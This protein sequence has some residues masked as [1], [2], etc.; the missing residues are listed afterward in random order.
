MNIINPYRFDSGI[1]GP[2]TFGSF[3]RE[4][5]GV[6][7]RL[8][9]P[10]LPMPT[11]AHTICCWVY[12]EQIGTIVNDIFGAWRSPNLRG[13]I[14]ICSSGGNFVYYISGD[15]S[16]YVNVTSSVNPSVQTW[17]HVAVVYEPNTHLKIYIDGVLTGTNTTNIFSSANDPTSTI[18]FSVGERDD[19]SS[20]TCTGGYIADLRVYDSDI[21]STNI[22]AIES[23]TH[24]TTD[25][26][27]WWLT[28]NDDYLDYS[29]NNQTAQDDGIM[30][31][32]STDAPIPS[33]TGFGNSSLL[34]NGTSTDFCVVG[35]SPEYH[36]GGTS[37]SPF[38]A[39]CWMKPDVAN[40]FRMISVYS[41]LNP[42]G[43]EWA[44]VNTNAGELMLLL[45]RSNTISLLAKCSNDNM[46]NYIGSWVHV[47][48][49]YDGRGGSNA[50][51]GIK[52][53][54]NGVSSE[55]TKTTNSQYT[56]MPTTPTDLSIG[57]LGLSTGNDYSDG[58]LSDCRVYDKV[59]S[60]SEVQDLESGTDVTSGLIGHWL[61]N[62][63]DFQDYSPS[64]NY[65]ETGSQ[66]ADESP[67]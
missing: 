17:Y 50:T 5:D 41:E 9:L 1:T 54:I 27:G 13:N 26:V 21:G 65:I 31:S 44:F 49:T 3:S 57:W 66:F 29:G 43:K 15:G 22:Q 58:K 34:L 10:A 32:F 48:C 46:N 53:Y 8:A 23:G 47:A 20:V 61:T 33:N 40:R 7:D 30:P 42:Q 52:L 60:L 18:N 25:L 38:S 51:D 45:A 2:P 56:N 37:D 64:G 36:F 59:L 62:N 24:V 55:D 16:N 4:F 39:A 67:F 28:D 14:L 6:N 19:N 11:G 35:D 63:N 12:L